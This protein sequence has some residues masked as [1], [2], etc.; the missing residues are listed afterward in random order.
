MRLIQLIAGALG[1]FL[2]GL[3]VALVFILIMPLALIKWVVPAWRR[4]CNRLLDGIASAWIEVNSWHQRWLTGTEIHVSGD[5]NALSRNEWYMLIANHQSWVDIMILLRLF[6]RRIPYVKFFFKQE[7]LWVPFFGQAMWALDFP[8]M[9][10]RSKMSRRPG[11]D[12]DLARTRRACEVYRHSPVTIINFLEGTRFTPEKH[13][14]QMRQ[15]NGDTFQHLLKPKAGGFA[16]TLAAMDG[17]LHK[18]LDVTLHYPDGPPSFWDYACGRVQRV[19]VHWR[20]LP[21]PDTMIGDYPG[22]KEFRAR[23]QQW[24]N[25]LWKEKDQQL[26]TMNNT[27]K[28]TGAD[29]G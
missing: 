19:N 24:V 3:T 21:I 4:P 29:L 5:V 14:R 28:H 26:D 6:N 23:F 2:Y 1:F 18:L 20:V 17:Q 25:Q 7:L 11:E 27:P 8:V 15:R 10:R 16:F 9:R 22:D 12:D 13:A